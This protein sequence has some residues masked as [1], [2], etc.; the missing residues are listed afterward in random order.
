MK[1]GRQQLVPSDP[2]NIHQSMVEKVT[3][4]ISDSER[5][6]DAFAAQIR[7]R[8]PAGKFANAPARSLT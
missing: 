1:T 8:L 2:L 6:T 3:R 7:F 5:H 4:G